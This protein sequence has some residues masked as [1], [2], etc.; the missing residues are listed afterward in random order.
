MI[1]TL[2]KKLHVVFL[3][4]DSIIHSKNVV[5][6]KN[7]NKIIKRKLVVNFP[8]LGKKHGGLMRKIMPINCMKIY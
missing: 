5:F 6:E 3:K 2:L 1:M 7:S 4:K 8:V